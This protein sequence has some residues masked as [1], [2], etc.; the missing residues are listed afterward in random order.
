MRIRADAKAARTYQAFFG[1]QSVLDSHHADIHKIL[2]VVFIGK[3][4][5][6]LNK[7]CR[8][9]VLVWCKV[10]HDHCDFCV[11]K[12]RSSAVLLK[13]IDRHGRG[14][15][16]AEHHIELG[17]DKLTCLNLAQSR[18]SRKNFLRHCH[19]HKYHSN[20][21]F[22]YILLVIKHNCKYPFVFVVNHLA[23]VGDF[24]VSARVVIRSA[25]P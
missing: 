2:D 8:L 10:V 13:N 24:R 14:N 3:V 11:V 7:C 25:D 15:V 12:H 6:L 18:V 9:D 21:Y 23:A 20:F 16:V 22:V 19:S 5:R 4:S 17:V 1:K